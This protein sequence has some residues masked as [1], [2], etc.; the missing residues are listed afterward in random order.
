VGTPSV[1]R[2]HF[3]R[4]CLAAGLAVLWTATLLSLRVGG[5]ELTR[6]LSATA[7]LAGPLFATA[8]TLQAARHA[9]GRTRVAWVLVGV[10]AA[11][12]ATGAVAAAY[13]GL[14]EGESGTAGW[15]GPAYLAALGVLLVAVLTLP[16]R[17]RTASDRL[18]AA[19]DGLIVFG[20]LV[21][22]AWVGL[23]GPAVEASEL[24]PADLA[25][26]LARPLGACVLV[27]LVTGV[28]LGYRRRGIPGARL[29][30]VG[31]GLVVL[32]GGDAA[33][34]YLA[35][36]DEYG[37]GSPVD[38]VWLAAWLLVALGARVPVRPGAATPGE[39]EP[40]TVSGALPALLPYLG[41]LVAVL[42]GSLSLARGDEISSSLVGV[43]L[44]LLTLG[45]L[46]QL[47][48]LQESSA[49]ARELE[50]RVA[51][52][53]AEIRVR[54]ERFRSLVQ[55]SS[56]VVLVVDAG[57]VIRYASPSVMTV[58]G[59]RPDEVV[60]RPVTSVL[61][62]YDLSTFHDLLEAAKAQPATPVLGELNLQDATGTARTCES[63]LTSLLHDASVNGV[64]VNSRDVTERRAL[65]AQ[66]LHE[67]MH[68]R[69]TGLP[70]RALFGDRLRRCLASR[71]RRPRPVGVLVLDL[72]GFKALNDALGPA[73][74][75]GLLAA[76][77][78]RLR[79]VVRAEDTV[80]RLG[81]DEFGL[82]LEEMDDEADAAV[83]AERVAEV[84][85]APFVVDGKEI[86]IGATTGI[87][88]TEAL[89]APDD[90]LRNADLAL[91][92][93]KLSRRGGYEHY[94][95][96][97]HSA[98]ALRR[99]IENDLRGALEREELVLHYQPLVE[100]TTGRIRSLEALLRWNHP[101]R[102]LLAPMT[103]VPIA[104]ETG[105][106]VSIGQWV[107]DQACLQAAQWQRRF[108]EPGV[109]PV[110]MAVNLSGRQLQEA[111]VVRHVALALNDSQL[112][113]ESLTLEITE[114]L[115]LEDDDR[116]MHL[117]GALKAMGV[118][119]AIDD[120][121]TG[122]SSL[123]YLHRLPVDVLKVDRS[124]VQLL[125]GEPSEGQELA[126]TVVQLGHSLGLDTVAEGIETEA[127]LS[128]LKQLGCETG[129]GFYF[130][131]PVSAEEVE[132]LLAT[133]AA[134][135][136]AL[137]PG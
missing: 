108:A 13:P 91:H 52:R 114:S 107:L 53:T 2:R 74:A 120:F 89:E 77:A 63:V 88:V 37:T 66:L 38:A 60:G 44:L 35:A 130:S 95:S 24:P 71:G 10:A 47:V 86:R 132:R 33:Y 31:L 102:G 17:R 81:G 99:G 84:L 61:H 100:L 56:D 133:Q 110:G 101:E 42:C 121:G 12:W 34:A 119:L 55:H 21:V 96:G 29:A 68:D 64:V 49:L 5:T 83:V 128:A 125:A 123:A 105:L 4:E 93:A 76:V 62:P 97:L 115:L 113:P 112:D 79:T 51:V 134:F 3:R 41:I 16:A 48:I 50:H 15:A 28:V 67:S 69:L 117:L 57:A 27:A 124:F 127:E 14:T 58:L 8:A 1:L 103:F 23:L 36:R 6:A 122:Y 65:Q 40:E 75:D 7:L 20:S 72:D 126:R 22:A 131:R 70:N 78:D 11:V 19:L 54:E 87:A 98:L 137:L 82:L 135:G 9:R 80:A 32:G 43:A 92:R 18:K 30:L 136:P 116:A 94:E 25:V 90:L 106:I 39:A 46:R 73:R 59:V 26:A 85:Q 129:Q 118:R 104:E 111:D 109:P 45:M